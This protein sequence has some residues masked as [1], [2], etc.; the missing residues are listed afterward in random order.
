MFT[1]ASPD[2]DS[3]VRC[4]ERLALDDG[5]CERCE[6][7]YVLKF[8]RMSTSD[9]VAAA[10]LRRR[11]FKLNLLELYALEGLP[12]ATVT[13]PCFR[14]VSANMCGGLAP[15]GVIDDCTVL[16]EVSSVE[17]QDC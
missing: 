10:E 5:C 15:P 14:C 2:R 13:V 11:S 9:A 3:Y 16:S 12:T 8:Q 17:I 4:K 6:P 1:T 7:P